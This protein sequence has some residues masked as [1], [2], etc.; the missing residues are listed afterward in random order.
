MIQEIYLK[1]FTQFGLVGGAFI[2]LILTSVWYQRRYFMLMR[3]LVNNNT[4]ALER[5]SHSIGKTLL[6]GEQAIVF[7]NLVLNEHINK[8]LAFVRGVLTENHIDSRPQQIK[9]NLRSKFIEITSKE[10]GILKGFNSVAG[11]MGK[12]LL[13]F[14]IDLVLEATYKI[15]FSSD[16]IDNKINDLRMYMNNCVSDLIRTIEEKIEENS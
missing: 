1:I 11:D 12:I 16:S 7:F 10:A 9:D 15:V 14:D 2:I 5:M 6:S 4:H 13:S 8:K 3:D